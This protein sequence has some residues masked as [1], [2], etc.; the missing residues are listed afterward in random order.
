MWRFR[1][2]PDKTAIPF[3]GLRRTFFIVSIALAAASVVVLL[4]RGLNFGIDF[5]GGI[6][7]EVGTQREADIG[8]MRSALGGLDLGE[9]A[10]QEF[11]SPTEVLI[12][13]ERQPG[14]ATAQQAA[15]ATVRDALSANYGDTLSYRRVETV[16][17]KVGAE[18]IQAGIIAV[19]VSVFLMLVYIWF[20]FELPFAIGA[21]IALIHDVLLSLGIFAALGLE[22]NL[23]IVAA[24]LLIVGYSMNDTVVVYDRVREN[25][26]KYKTLPLLALLNRSVNET[27][28]R[29][30]ITSL[31]TLLALLALLIFGGA[32]IRDFS[33][34]MIWGVIVGTYSSVFIAGALLLTVQPQRGGQKR[35]AGQAER[36]AAIDE[37]PAAKALPPES[38]PALPEPDASV[39]EPAAAAEAAEAESELPRRERA[40]RHPRPA[41]R[42]SSGARAPR[43][44]GGAGAGAA[45]AEPARWISRRSFPKAG[46]SSRATATGASASTANAIPAP[47]RPGHRLARAGGALGGAGPRGRRRRLARPAV[48]GRAPHRDPADRQ[49]RRV[50]TGSCRP[51]GGARHARH[52]RRK[53]G[54]RRRLPHLQRADGRGPPRRRGANSGAAGLIVPSLR[55]RAAPRAQGP[56]QRQGAASVDSR[57]C[58]AG[59]N[60]PPVTPHSRPIGSARPVSPPPAASL[61]R[62]R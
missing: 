24:I 42:A 8:Q 51:A 40:R 17:P 56:L 5:A 54:H 22:F 12:R 31:T 38:A 11:G 1:L 53:H 26:R 60:Y 57:D 7:I 27:L 16:G 25:L 18:L 6:L 4:A 37:E 32:V 49:R 15:V 28:A 46:R 3:L 23:P 14:D 33:F 61:P 47:S 30:V 55:R 29:T 13:I 43:G 59:F 48:L 20:R 34:A 41:G 58:A 19:V 9:I 21:V 36:V 2:I 45:R 44:R 35:A 50:C 52:R 10:L 39:A 62:R